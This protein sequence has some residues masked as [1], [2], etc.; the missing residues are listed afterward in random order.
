M[1]AN[2]DV[3]PNRWR[4]GRTLLRLDDLGGRFQPQ[5]D[6][7]EGYNPIR[8]L[9]P[10]SRRLQLCLSAIRSPLCTELNRDPLLPEKGRIRGYSGA[11]RSGLRTL[12]FPHGA[13]RDQGHLEWIRDKVLPRY[14]GP[15]RSHQ[16]SPCF[17]LTCDG[18]PSQVLGRWL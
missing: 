12:R 1:H 6:R 17:L 18:S 8:F 3:D 10:L 2:L 14:S 15:V 9:H 11:V 13:S 7:S 16:I 5:S 4:S